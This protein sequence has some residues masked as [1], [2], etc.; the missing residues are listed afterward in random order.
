[1]QKTYTFDFTT[2]PKNKQKK[3]T[4]LKAEVLNNILNF[5]RSLEVLKASVS[6]ATGTPNVEIVLN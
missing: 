4:G 3:E 2:S 6:G 5:S 1:M